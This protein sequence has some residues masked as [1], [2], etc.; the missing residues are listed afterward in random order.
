[1]TADLSSLKVAFHVAAPCPPWL[2]QA[3][4]DW[5]GPE[6]VYELYAGTELQA[7]TVITGTEWLEHRGSVGRVV[8]GEIEIRDLD[9]RPVPPD[10]E[11]E[12][13]M[14]RGPAAPPPYWYIGATARS[15]DGGWESLGDIGRVDPDGYVYITDRLTD[16]ILI[17]GANV[18]PAEIEAALDEHP[19]VQ[20]SCVIGLPDEDLGNI[21]HAIVELSKPASDEHLMVHLRQRLAPHK[22]PRTIERVATPLRD[23]AGKV[24][25]SALRAERLAQYPAI[26]PS[27]IPE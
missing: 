21:P 20:S 13:W 4:I 19:A 24:R 9:G 8:L 5:L 6:K 1:M 3:W 15:T 18:Y 2:K 14:R 27:A 12:I 11:G 16:M 23:D 22:L 10:E 17:G 7:A 25:R 26:Q